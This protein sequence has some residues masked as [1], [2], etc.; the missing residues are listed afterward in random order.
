M[1]KNLSL[2]ENANLIT[3]FYEMTVFMSHE[4]FGN[5]VGLRYEVM[6]CWWADDGDVP[7]EPFI[8]HPITFYNPEIME[9]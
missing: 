5:I 9:R 6:R 3:L 8:H 2:G 1:L 4:S 7:Y